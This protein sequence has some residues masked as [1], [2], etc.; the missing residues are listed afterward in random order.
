MLYLDNAASGRITDATI[1]YYSRLLREDFAN[2]EALHHEAYRLR[3]SLQDAGEKSAEVFDLPGFDTFLFFNSV[4]EIFHFL[5]LYFAGES[6]LLNPL[7]HPAVLEN[8]SRNCRCRYLRCSKDASVT[9][10]SGDEKLLFIHHVQSELGKIQDIPGIAEKFPAATIIVDAAQSAGKLPL[11]ETAH[12]IAISGVKMGAPGGAVLLVSN[13]SDHAEKISAFYRK[14][15]SEHHLLP[16][17]SVPQILTMFFAAGT[18][19]RNRQQNLDHVTK[20][21]CRL[22][23]LC[24]D[25][26]VFP[27]LPAGTETSPYILN[28]SLPGQQGAVVVRTLAGMDICVAA[29]SAC[30]A[31]S[32]APSPALQ[33]IGLSK[34]KAYNALRVS[35]DPANTME[36]VDFFASALKNVLKNY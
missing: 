36:E 4:T 18:L 31:E 10:V 35:F 19:C 8:I 2:Q 32:G 21:N 5:G 12:M 26:G 11:P 23:S 3:K 34:E 9:A 29:G 15:R 24:A 7:E 17:V 33:A 14:A 6:A 28:L 13:K 27:T 22:T 1:E 25:F 16:R 20:L 30:A